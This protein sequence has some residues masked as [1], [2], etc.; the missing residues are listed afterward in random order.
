LNEALSSV[1][2]DSLPESRVRNSQPHGIGRVAV[3]DGLGAWSN[4]GRNVVF[5][6]PD[7]RPRAVFD[8][9]VFTEDEPSQYDLDVHA[10]LDLPGAGMILTLNHL[11]MLRA[12]RVADVKEP[13]P[14][15]RVAPEWTR[16]FAADVERAVV[17]DGRLVGSRP[18]AERAPGLLVSEPLG[19]NAARAELDVIGELDSWGMVT[20]LTPLGEY[21]AGSVAVGG[22]GRVSV[23]TVCGDRTGATRWDTNVDFEPAV[24]LWDGALVWAAGCEADATIDDYDWDARH[25][26]GFAALDPVDGHVVVRGRFDE[27]LAWGA[28]GVAIA[29]VPGAL[30]GFGRRGQLHVFDRRDGAPLTTTAPSADAS[31]GIAHGAALGDHLVYGFNRG[32]YR[33]RTVPIAS[34]QNV[35]RSRPGGSSAPAG[36]P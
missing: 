32:G 28:G 13:G 22:G 5:V 8:E 20:A 7:L 3:L 27:D 30:C 24:L 10:I 31:L 9:S 18:R 23:A 14:V 6:G 29:L 17:V 16:T 34:V 2:I 33:L 1:E 35:V 21:A 25:G 4:L 19:M 36:E 26:G 11:G 15:R 12:F